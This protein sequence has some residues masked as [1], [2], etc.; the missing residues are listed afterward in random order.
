MVRI[1]LVTG[2]TETEYTQDPSPVT[3]TT[4]TYVI[5]P[6][7]EVGL[8][9]EASVAVPIS[10]SAPLNVTVVISPFDSAN[11]S[12]AWNEPTFG[13][14][15]FT[16][17][18]VRAAGGI[19]QNPP[20]TTIADGTLAAGVVDQP[21]TG[22]WR[23]RV[24]AVNA[25]DS[26]P[27]S[28][29][30]GV[31]VGLPEIL[32]FVV[33]SAG[34]E[35]WRINPDNPGD[36]SGDYGLVG[37][38]P[39][40]LTNPN[41]I[42]YGDGRWL[43]VDNTGDE[44]WRINPDN[45]GD[46]SGDY[47]L[48]GDLPSGLAA[49]RGGG[50]GDSRWLIVD[51]SGGEL[52]RINPDNPGDEG[53]V[54]GLAGTLPSGLTNPRGIGYGDGRWLVVDSSG[55]TLWRIN[56]DNPGDESGDYG[57][58]GDLPPRLTSPNG[59]GYG[60]GRWL[61]VDSTG[62]TLWRINPDNPGDASGDYGLVGDLPSGLTSPLGVGYDT[63][64]AIV[65][66]AP[67][68]PTLSVID[69][70]E[71]IIIWTEPVGGGDGPYIY[72]LVRAAAGIDPNPPTTTIESDTSATTTTDTP[73]DGAWR[74]RVRAGNTAGDGP[75]SA[76]ASIDVVVDPPG[77]VHNLV[78]AFSPVPSDRVNVDWDAP[79]T[80]GTVDDYRIER[81]VGLG[82][83]TALDTDR[84][85][86]SYTDTAVNAGTT[87]GYRVRAQGPGGVGP[88]ET[89][90]VQ[91]PAELTEPGPVGD[92]EIES[93]T[94]TSLEIDWTYPDDDGGSPITGYI[95]EY[96]TTVAPPNTP[97]VEVSRSGTVSRQTITG[98]EAGTSYDVR[99]AAVNAQ[100]TGSYETV[101]GATDTEA[102]GPV[103]NLDATPSATQVVVDWDPPN[104]GG[105]V[106]D[107][108]IERRVGL[109]AWTALDTDRTVSSYTDTAVN[110]GTTYGYRV[111]AQGPGGVGPYETT[112]V[113]V[114]A[115]LTEPG[116]VGDL[117][118]ESSTS[119]SLEIDWTYP[120]DDGGSPITGY[121]VEYRTTV[122]PPN[123]PF[124]EVSRSGTVSRQTITGLEAGTSYD[125]RVAAVN[126]Q[127]TG[128]YETVS[129]A[130]DTEAPGPVR[131]LD[132]TP[133][134]TQ[135]VVDWDPPNTGGTVDDYR[136]ERRVGLGAWTALDTDRTVSSYTDT[137]V[138]AGTTYGYRVRAQ[139]PGGVGP[140]ETTSVQVPA[141]LTEP[142]PV[143]D[144]EIE[145][146]TSTSLEI[147]W[148]YPDDDG[149]SPITGYI[150]EYR[151]TV[152]PPN[153]PFVEV[154]RSGTVSRQTITGL[155]AGTSYDVR[156]AAVNAQ[157]TGPYET[158]SGATDTE[159][160]G[161]VRNLDATPSATQVVVDWDPPNTGGT[162]DDYRIERRVGLGAWTLLDDD[163]TSTSYTDTAVTPGNTYGY[164]VRAQGPGGDSAYEITSAEI[165]AVD[166]PGRVTNVDIRYLTDSDRTLVNWDAPTT[167]GPVTGYRVWRGNTEIYSGTGTIHYDNNPPSGM[168]TYY[169]AAVG[170]G[171]QGPQESGAVDVPAE[172]VPPV[173]AFVG[174]FQLF[175][176]GFIFTFDPDLD[177]N[178]VPP[179]SAFA[180]FGVGI[181]AANNVNFVTQNPYG[182]VLLV[183]IAE[184]LEPGTSVTVTYT[185]PSS[186]SQRL[187]D[188]AGNEVETFILSHTV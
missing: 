151:T 103:R 170:P 59:I 150:V 78:A 23:Y 96:R 2:I 72:D 147:D 65:P 77:P 174:V 75:W 28:G 71:V 40:G 106:D 29:W 154:S 45:P 119:T 83:W 17:D 179:T 185:K 153:T 61:V 98:L 76:W 21:S 145:S 183:G 173:P 159:A 186:V 128:P 44:L 152:A 32:L 124:V 89:T 100:G 42:A 24:R 146:S 123:T 120:D 57:L 168:H 148:T 130:T 7:N 67:D 51:S 118:I 114:P 85:V 18:V 108:R 84:T 115:E 162:V 69:S 164:R 163:R 167:G 132:A 158:V 102:P 74:Y 31:N 50:Y 62:A 99:V 68:A 20:T 82:A 169:I 94:S 122:A 80:G 126:A 91:V 110:A 156:V 182:R 3:G 5:T 35:L 15:P 129:G 187:Q 1:R 161:P 121:I 112:S 141:E 101:S 36:V 58:V 144:L 139:G 39:S 27:W 177:E 64:A 92:L 134:A 140:Y 165:P 60:D 181:Y 10:P 47:G 63:S 6:F 125:V 142:G 33:D 88:Y 188:S 34:D 95:V 19:E 104:T 25:V 26:G 111:R 116:P 14:T 93:S 135:V 37:D 79:N 30:V 127:G 11:V 16:Y 8:G 13:D 166:A 46:A 54:Y 131:N 43:V 87:Y 52:W 105:T 81:R 38:L 180:V 157:G 90:S 9:P 172:E 133:S 113:Q 48:V 171:G 86:S 12:I 137:A 22:A 55:D 56:P 184:N 149:G 138:N 155:E 53:G 49:P 4:P 175:G 160:P 107:Y 97:F 178:H 41:G 136:I 66:G 143:G 176:T 109:G 70:G 73:G 117:E